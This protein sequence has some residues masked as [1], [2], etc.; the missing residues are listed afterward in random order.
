MTALRYIGEGRWTPGVPAADV[1]VPEEQAKRLV[2]SGLYAYAD[3]V[4][5]DDPSADHYIDDEDAQPVFDDSPEG[6]AEDGE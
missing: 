5:E 4:V 1:D 3:E 6:V 2:E